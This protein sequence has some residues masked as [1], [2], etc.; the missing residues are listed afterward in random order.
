MDMRWTVTSTSANEV[1]CE[2]PLSTGQSIMGQLLL[3][4]SY[5][6]APRRFFRFNVIET[7]GVSRVQAAGWMETQMAFG[8]MKRVDFAGAP[9]HNGMMGFMTGAGGRF[10]MGTTFPHH[11]VMGFNGK[12]IQHGR[13][14]AV[15]VEEVLPNTPAA[16]AGLQPAD[17]ITRIAGKRFKNDDEYLETLERA[18]KS[19]TY[20]IEVERNGSAT[21][22]TLDREFRPAYAEV[23]AP[24]PLNAIANAESSPTVSVADE[25]QKLVKLKEQGILTQAEFD[26][27]KAKL[28]SR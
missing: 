19:P 17:V 12:N 22:M 5:S 16:R 27:Q 14:V 7:A 15:R 25:L 26:A 10:P 20:T 6:T 8:Q 1:I 2:A 28:L 4:N 24:K 3:G 9:F 23:V 11:V 21:S 18:A 13:Y